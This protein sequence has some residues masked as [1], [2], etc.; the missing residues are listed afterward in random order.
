VFLADR[1]PLVHQQAEVLRAE[2]GLHVKVRHYSTGL[3]CTVL[4][5]IVL[6]WTRAV[7]LFMR[8]ALASLLCFCTPSGLTSSAGA[9]SHA[10]SCLGR[11]CVCV[12]LGV[13]VVTR[14]CA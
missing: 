7:R 10:A 11:A 12:L 6:Y 2:A 9:A 1:I 14:W 13:P 3:Y 8:T 4:C 5:C